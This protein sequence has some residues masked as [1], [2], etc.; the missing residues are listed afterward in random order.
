M[1]HSEVWG[2]IR[3][4]SGFRKPAAAIYLTGST[5]DSGEI[6]IQRFQRETLIFDSI[7]R[8]AE[9]VYHFFAQGEKRLFSP[10]E[11]TV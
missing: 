10:W 5:Q 2:D 8:N 9:N 11:C 3:F 6:Q 4:G 7:T 1:T